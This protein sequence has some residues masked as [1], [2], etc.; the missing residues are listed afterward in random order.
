[1]HGAVAV[2]VGEDKGV[3]RECDGCSERRCAL[4]RRPCRGG[5]FRTKLNVREALPYIERAGDGMIDLPAIKK[6]MTTID[7]Q[8]DPSGYLVSPPASG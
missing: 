5:G 6:L 4:L 1:M 8:I 7:A 3:A 2:V